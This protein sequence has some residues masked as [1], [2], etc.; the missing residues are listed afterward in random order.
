MHQK[1]LIP[2]DI[3]NTTTNSC[4]IHECW[5]K[6]PN[7]V[8]VVI[9]FALAIMGRCSELLEGSSGDRI[10]DDRND[11]LFP[12]SIVLGIGEKIERAV[13]SR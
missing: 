7:S 9:L 2:I 4:G 11:Y 3:R 1:T 13:V 12:R 5:I 8:G 6:Y 10:V